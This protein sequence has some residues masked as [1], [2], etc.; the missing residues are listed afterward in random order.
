VNSNT[1]GTNSP[2]FSYQP[3]DDD[4]VLCI[5]TTPVGCYT[6]NVAGSTIIVM[7]VTPPTPH[8]FNVVAP[9]IAEVG[10]TVTVSANVQSAITSYSIQWYNKGVLFA[11]TTTNTTT[12]AKTQGI[13]TITAV[14]TP[15]D[16]CYAVTTSAQWFVYS[17]ATGVNDIN[18]TV[19]SV[20]PNPFS[21][22]LTVK[23]IGHGDKIVLYDMTGKK[24]MEWEIAEDRKEQLLDIRDLPAGSYMLRV[25]DENN[26]A[27]VNQA[28]QKLQ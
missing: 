23:G 17:V 19:V 20:Y 11:T 1:V 28:L 18:K 16:A 10:S 26:E 14:I 27:I 22:K 4:I 12:Y 9:G 13:D 6:T 24:L 25:T 2:T 8:S 3:V 5:V 7:S 15:T 21:D